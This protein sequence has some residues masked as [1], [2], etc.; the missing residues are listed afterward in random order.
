MV[1]H[2]FNA[3]SPLHHREPGIAGRCMADPALSCSL[4]VDGI[5]VHPTMVQNAF[6]CLGPERMLLVTD[7]MAAAGMPDGVYSLGSSQVTLADGEV[8]DANG[9]LAGS[10][11]LMT[12]AVQRFLE[13]VPGTDGSHVARLASTNPARLLGLTDMGRIA[14]GTAPGFSLLTEDGQVQAIAL[15]ES[16]ASTL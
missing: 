12:D 15:E 8:R 1:T 11:I 13:F 14:P 16:S 2:L 10:A 5:H 6:R 3:M 4:I 7:C 9:A